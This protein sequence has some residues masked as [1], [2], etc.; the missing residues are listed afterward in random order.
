MKFSPSSIITIAAVVALGA[1]A[2]YSESIVKK[3]DRK[4]GR[5]VI[6]Y[7]EKWTNFEADAMRAVVDEFNASQD[8]IFV[9][10]LSVSGVA[11]KTL[12]AVS[13]GIPPDVAGLFG[14]NTPQYAFNNAVMPLDELCKE[15]GISRDQYIS[16]YYDMCT[17]KGKLWALP[18]MPASTALHYN[19]ALYE[20]A[21]IDSKNPPK[22]IEELDAI[23]KKMSIV[24]KNG[25]IVRSGYM[26]TEPNWW[27]WSWPG[28]FGGKLWDGKGTITMTD[29]NTIKAYE[30]VASY[31]KR[32]GP[33][34]MQSF[35]QG[36]GGFD[37]AQN[38]FMDN[39][40]AS[41]N[42]GVWMYN[43]VSKYRPDFKLNIV[44]FPHPQDRPDL[45]NA[46]VIDLDI[47]VIPRGAKHPK[48]AFEFIKFVQ[49]NKGMELLAIGQKKHSPLIKVT[50]GF[51]ENHPNPFVK[52]FADLA[53]SK[54]ALSPPKTPIWP[55]W[56]AELGAA[57]Q[58]VNLGTMSAK[59]AMQ[60][61]QNKMQPILDD[62]ARIERERGLIDP[63]EQ[64]QP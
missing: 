23:D 31:S 47:L 45:A 54:N 43:F 40:V 35:Q 2:L 30:W 8:K 51:Y 25:K 42:Q 44:P 55:E 21:G 1:T 32:Y 27:P 50:P 37:S 20:E 13:G 7:W 4:D 62:V 41:V 17:Y 18:T 33:G 5:V 6:T 53:K 11:Q 64:V 28:V 24:D 9:E 26:P 57:F 63:N 56:Q 60:K 58:E 61:V 52:L 16:V 39:K 19:M 48:E 14:P 15:N 34:N 22:T 59:E 46:T 12:M 10:Y 49:S 29:P 3:P 36:F 38:A